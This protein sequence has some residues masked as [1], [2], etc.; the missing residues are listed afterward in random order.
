MIVAMEKMKTIYISNGGG[1][2]GRVSV[3]QAH[4]DGG[5]SFSDDK[6]LN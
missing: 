4:K 1:G 6:V 2:D 5:D 3:I